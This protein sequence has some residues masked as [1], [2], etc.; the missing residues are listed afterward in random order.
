VTGTPGEIKLKLKWLA[1]DYKVNELVAIT[2]AEDFDDR[3]ESYQLLA[4][5]FEITKPE[6]HTI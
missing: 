6:Y 1:E 3:L 4:E 5:Q 2:I